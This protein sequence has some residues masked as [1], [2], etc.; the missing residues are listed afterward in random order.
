MPNLQ[1]QCCG[2]PM[3]IADPIPRDAECESCRKD[4]RSCRNCRHFD[5]R[6]NNSCRE[7]EADL[8]EDKERRNFCEYFS[9]NP[10]PFA[11]KALKPGRETEARSKLEGLFGGASN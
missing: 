11:A 4:L 2:A 8:V 3:L 10:A 9:F 6:L 7:T 1:C 5:P